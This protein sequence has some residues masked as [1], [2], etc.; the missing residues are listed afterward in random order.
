MRFFGRSTRFSSI[1]LLAGRKQSRCS[2]TGFFNFVQGLQRNIF[3][4]TKAKKLSTS[5]LV[6]VR[7]AHKHPTDRVCA[8]VNLAICIDFTI[9]L[10][11]EFTLNPLVKGIIYEIFRQVSAILIKYLQKDMVLL[12]IIKTNKFVRGFFDENCDGKPAPHRF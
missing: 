7:C 3:V 5:L 4:K 11:Q 6:V 1:F 10:I 2:K 8:I 12:T 9:I